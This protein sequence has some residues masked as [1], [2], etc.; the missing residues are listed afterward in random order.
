MIY[1]GVQVLG[2]F[3]SGNKHNLKESFF[4]FKNVEGAKFRLKSLSH[5]TYTWNFYK[6]NPNDQSE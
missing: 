6:I 4:K 3:P 5:A 1:L 2:T